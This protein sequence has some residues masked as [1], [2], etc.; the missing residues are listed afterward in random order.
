MLI[1]PLITTRAFWRELVYTQAMQIKSA[2]FIKGVRGTDDIVTDGIPQIAFVG[3][4][5]VGKSSVINSLCNNGGLAKV[6]KKPGKTT[7]I[8]FFSI[9]KD[10][11]YIVDLPGYGYA[12]VSPKE[13]DMLKKL[14]YW[15]VAD[16]E[17][18]PRVLVVVI[19]TKVGITPY[20]TEMIDLLRECGQNYIIAANKTDK[21]TQKGLFEKLKEMKPLAQGAKIIPCTTTKQ[22]GTKMLF[23]KIFN[24]E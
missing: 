17:V 8:N 3:R 23:E 15:Y 2:T 14:I 9:N 18:K 22:N 13:K 24:D 5:N 11:L 10:Q 12:K 16:S 7:E 6:G 1:G 4:S 21:L 19:D 20:D